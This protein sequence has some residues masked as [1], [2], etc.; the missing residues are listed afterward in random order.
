MNP[1]NR[2]CCAAGVSAFAPLMKAATVALVGNPG[3]RDGMGAGLRN[4]RD[5]AMSDPNAIRTDRDLGQRLIIR[6]VEIAGPGAIIL[7]GPSS[8]GKGEVAKALCQL[9][10][11]GRDRWL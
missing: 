1:L 7:T 5:F 6:Q 9:L 4:G 8:C 2:I 11:I 3:T 10:D